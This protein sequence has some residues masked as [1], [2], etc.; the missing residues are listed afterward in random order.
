MGRIISAEGYR[1]NPKEMEI[2]QGKQM[3]YYRTFSS[4]HF[5]FLAPHFTVYT[6]N[7]PLTYVTKSAKLNATGH[8]WIVDLADYWFT[9]TYRAGT[10]NRDADFLSRHKPIRTII[11][12]CTEECHQ[13]DI[14]SIVNAMEIESKGE[15]NWISAITFNIDA[16]LA[17]SVLEVVLLHQSS[18]L[19]P[20][21]SE[22]LMR[23]MQSCS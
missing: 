17:L 8:R 20:K 1:M 11:Q 5:L 12:E 16:L 6:D 22:Q 7:N 19:Q 15:V 4:S 21:T 14:E 23:K 18:S 9:I 13:E 10:A 2:V 3:G